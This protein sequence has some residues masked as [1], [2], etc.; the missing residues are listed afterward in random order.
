MIE[1]PLEFTRSGNTDH[2][3]KLCSIA[4]E[5]CFNYGTAGF[6]SL[7]SELPFVIFRMGYLA[8]LRSRYL[9]KVIG[10]V[11]TA[12]HNPECDNGVK[13]VDP[14]GEMLDMR[15]EQF[16]TNLVN[17]SD[18]EYPSKC[19]HLEQ[20][21]LSPSGSKFGEVICG[22]DTR[23]SSKYLAEA[24]Q[25]GVSSAKCDFTLYGLL[26]TPQLHYIVRCR[27]NPAYGEPHEDGYYQK[28]SNA[29]NAFLDTLNLNRD[30][31]KK[32]II[33]CANGVGSLKLKKLLDS[34]R[35]GSIDYVLRNTSGILNLKCGADFVK[36]EHKFPSGFADTVSNIRCASVDGDADRLLYFYRDALGSFVLL[37]GDKIATLLAM[38]FQEHLKAAG[39]TGTLTLAVVQTAYANGNSVKFLKNALGLTTKI[40]AT[41]V[42]HLHNEARKYDIGIYFEANGHGTVLFS[43]KFK[44]IIGKYCFSLESA[45]EQI[46]V[47]RLRHLSNLINE[48]V[49]DAMSDLLAVEALLMFYNWTVRDWANNLYYDSPSCQLKVK[50][51]DRLAFKTTAD[52][53]R[54]ISPISLQSDIDKI[55]AKY[56]EGSTILI[57]WVA[58]SF[59]VFRPSGT[60]DVVRVYAEAKTSQ[61]AD[62]L[63]SSVAELV[64]RCV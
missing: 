15:W 54:L 63:A 42:K 11:I 44:Q 33:D 27:N 2:T 10:V 17:C 22:Y 26:T 25:S 61:E 23:P 30:Y 28:Y 34:V 13:I 35:H 40:V 31:S 9:N 12:S 6:R 29:F 41:G 62:E 56:D 53:T 51:R 57:V 38:F 18:S 24:L 64:K 50:V 36:L 37:D 59:C 58:F 20:E 14:M 4:K 39:L 48:V 21:L 60:E 5:R 46:E 49:G 19:L 8:G 32:L 7:A 52:E 43:Q 16:A 45:S 47:K 1:V 3:G 55:V